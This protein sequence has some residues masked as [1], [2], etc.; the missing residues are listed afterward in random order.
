MALLLLGM[1]MQAKAA[2][3]PY[4]S[5]SRKDSGPMQLEQVRQQTETLQPLIAQAAQGTAAHNVK[6]YNYSDA[7]DNGM[8]YLS[9]SSGV[10]FAMDGHMVYIVTAAHCLKRIHTAVQLADGSWHDGSVGYLNPEKDVAFL[11]LPYQ[12]LT[13]ETRLAIMPAAGADAAALGKQP[14]DL[15]FAVSSAQAPNALVAAGILDSCSVVYPNNPNQR[16]LQFY[17][18]V[19]YGSSGGGLYS[20]EGVLL[21]IVSGGD[22]YGICWAVP[23]GDILTEFQGWL[24]SL[25]IL[26]A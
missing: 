24:A 16:V 7:D 12:D 3:P 1:P 18:T 4:G 15:L 23:Y 6:V 13:A 8:Y 14:G 2:A 5:M 19:S 10:I 26:A 22:T 9:E 11:L 21:G 17:S 20:Q 25:T